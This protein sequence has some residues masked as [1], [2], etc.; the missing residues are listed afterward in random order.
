M[1]WF[2]KDEQIH[3]FNPSEKEDVI[4]FINSLLEIKAK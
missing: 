2:K 4:H 3:W 1:S